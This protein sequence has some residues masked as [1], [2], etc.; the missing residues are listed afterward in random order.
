MKRKLLCLFLVVVMLLTLVACGQKR[1]VIC[2]GCGTEI[3][4][5][6]NSNIT[7]EWIVFCEKCELELF[8]EDGVVAAE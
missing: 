8:G 4:V 2:D 5:K 3:T 7:D 6:D 1:T